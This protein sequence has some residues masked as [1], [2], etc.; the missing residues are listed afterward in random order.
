MKLHPS[1]PTALY[2]FVLSS[3]LFSSASQCTSSQEANRKTVI[4]TWSNVA[5]QS[6][7]VS[8]TWSAWGDDTAGAADGPA[9]VGAY[10]TP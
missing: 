9:S 5:N 2:L 4:H 8:V 1:F 3:T 6:Y 10:T 7:P